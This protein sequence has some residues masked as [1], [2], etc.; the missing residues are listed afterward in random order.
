ME[1]GEIINRCDLDIIH[2]S[3]AQI[4]STIKYLLRL[5]SQL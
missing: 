5:F 4:P 3:K 1:L 2:C